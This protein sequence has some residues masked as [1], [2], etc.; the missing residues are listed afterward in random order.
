MTYPLRWRPCCR[1]M[2]EV[3]PLTDW[4]QTAVRPALNLILRRLERMFSKIYKKSTL[5]VSNTAVGWC[6]QNSAYVNGGLEVDCRVEINF[7]EYVQ[8]TF[9]YYAPRHMVGHYAMMTIVRLSISQSVP[10]LILSRERKGVASWR[11]AGG[12]PMTWV[13]RDPFRGQK[14]MTRPINAETE[15]APHLRNGKAYELQTW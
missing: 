13:T 12:K 6:W 3:L 14:I 1:Y 7:A 8:C 4:S 2:L 15:N 5:R 9:D 10:C 11:L